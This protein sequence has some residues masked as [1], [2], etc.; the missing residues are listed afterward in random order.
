LGRISHF[1]RLAM[2]TRDLG[3]S[4]R[5][6][7]NW[8]AD[9]VH[10]FDGRIEWPN[11]APFVVTDEAIDAAFNDNGSFRW[12]SDFIAFAL[13][14]PRQRPQ[15]RVIERLRLIDLAFRIAHPERAA[16]IAK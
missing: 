2:A 8:I 9:V 5:E 1:Q 7:P 16:W 15:A 14:P 10:G 12:I 4:R 11:G 3:L 13:V 6:I